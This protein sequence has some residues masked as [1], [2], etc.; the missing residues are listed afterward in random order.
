MKFVILSNEKE[1]IIN[2]NGFL[3]DEVESEGNNRWENYCIKEDL[4]MDMLGI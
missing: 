3:I 2:D 1:L 4:L